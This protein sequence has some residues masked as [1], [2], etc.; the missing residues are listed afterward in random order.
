MLNLKGPLKHFSFRSLEQLAECLPDIKRKQR[1]INGGAG[2]AMRGRTAG[3]WAHRAFFGVTKSAARFPATIRYINAI[4]KDKTGGNWT[5]FILLRNVKMAVHR[6]NHNEVGTSTATLTFGQFQG[7]ELWIA[8]EPPS[9][10]ASK[11][12]I[13]MMGQGRG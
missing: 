1:A 11:L 8:G 2:R 13:A 3:V 10:T 4:M 5:S 7:G 9:S 6:D 12:H